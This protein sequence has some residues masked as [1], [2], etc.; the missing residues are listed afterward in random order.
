MTLHAQ[1]VFP[2]DVPI[3][4]LEPTLGFP[5]IPKNVL[6]GQQ[7][8]YAHKTHPHLLMIHLLKFHPL[9]NLSQVSLHLRRCAFLISQHCA[10]FRQDPGL[11][12]P[13]HCHQL[14]GVI[15]ENSE[16]VWPKLFMLPK[17]VLP[18]LR[19]QG[20]HDKPLPVD[21][22]CNMWTDND[23]GP[24]W[25]LAKGG[26]I[27]HTL[28]STSSIC[29][30]S[31][32]VDMAISLGRSG[33]FG[34][35]CWILQSSGIA[36]NSK[37]TW[38]LLK[39]KHPSCPA[40]VVPVVPNVE[41]IALQPD[42]NIISVL[43][44][45]PKHTAAGPSGLRVQHL[46][47]VA[48]IPLPTPICSSLRLVINIIE[49]GKAPT[50]VSQFLAGESLISLNKNKEGF[51]PDIRPIAMGETL[52]RL[53]GKCMCTL[54]KVKAADFFQPLQFGVVCYAGAEK[55]THGLRICLEEHWLDDDFVAFKVDMKR[56]L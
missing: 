13:E 10:S 51:A 33:M 3:T 31:N 21:V 24:L 52:R 37:N 1:G 6:E 22:L 7:L 11:P 20:R 17:C 8:P 44:S 2:G 38:Q 40:P 53:V 25:N 34:K 56:C 30:S 26:A 14:C 55:I 36:P 48:S 16:E 28:Q 32:N 15:Q 23:M 54:L 19:H 43:R 47:D 39:A 29:Q 9:T 4:W 12:L 35:A 27:S 50:S 46:L 45:F 49:A 5:H 41:S 18:S 42:F